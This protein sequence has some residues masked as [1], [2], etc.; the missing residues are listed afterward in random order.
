MDGLARASFLVARASVGAERVAEVMS[1]RSDVTD[2]EGAREASQLKGEIEFRDVSFEYE[3]GRAVL[4]HINLKIAQGEKVA[5][6]GATGAGM[7]TLVGLVPRFYDVCSAQLV[8]Q[9]R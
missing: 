3:T 7:S 4:S 9:C 1:I 8:Y 5:I 2:R 6:V